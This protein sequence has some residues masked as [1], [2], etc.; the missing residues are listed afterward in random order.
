MRRMPIH[1]PREG[2][3][4]IEITRVAA[5]RPEAR[6]WWSRY[7]LVTWDAIGLK[8]LAHWPLVHASGLTGF[9]GGGLQPVGHAHQDRD[10]VG[11]HLVHDLCAVDLDG[12]LR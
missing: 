5:G 4:S 8:P 9:L 3:R 2:R 1:L 6:Q 7:G 12:L 10:R 11:R